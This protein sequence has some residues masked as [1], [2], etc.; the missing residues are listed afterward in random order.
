MDASLR[1]KTIERYAPFFNQPATSLAFMKEQAMHTLF[2][3]C[4]TPCLL[5]TM[6]RRDM[7]LSHEEIATYVSTLSDYELA[8]LSSEK[9]GKSMAL[10]RAGPILLD[11][12]AEKLA[13]TSIRDVADLLDNVSPYLMDAATA[14]VY[15]GQRDTA[16][17]LFCVFGHWLDEVAGRELWRPELADR[18]TEAAERFNEQRD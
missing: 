8:R 7:S 16:D 12:L 5:E 9:N 4:P 10:R 1:R 15:S 17:H 14:A 6:V 2:E 13:E 3:Y 11:V 18:L